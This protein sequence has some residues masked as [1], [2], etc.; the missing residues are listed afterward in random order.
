[1]RYDVQSGAAGCS[2]FHYIIPAQTW[3]DKNDKEIDKN[4]TQPGTA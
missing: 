1:M 2:P 4:D 3:E